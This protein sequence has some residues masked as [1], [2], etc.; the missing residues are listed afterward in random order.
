[1]DI[2]CIIESVYERVKCACGCVDIELVYQRRHHWLYVETGMM[3]AVCL[4][5]LF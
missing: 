1:M 4:W 5:L 3:A 2:V